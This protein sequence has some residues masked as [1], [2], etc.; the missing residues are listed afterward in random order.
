MLAH[1]SSMDHAKED[2]SQRSMGKE[3]TFSATSSK[4]EIFNILETLAEGVSQ[5]LQK[6]DLKGRTVTLKVKTSKFELF[7]R[8]RTVRAPIHS[9]EDLIKVGQEIYHKNYEK[10]ESS[11]RL[12]GISLSKFCDE[13]SAE[14]TILNF[15]QYKKEK[16]DAPMLAW[17]K[18]REER[19]NAEKV[20][21]QQS[22]K[23]LQVR[24]E[25][26]PTNGSEPPPKSPIKSLSKKSKSLPNDPS[27]LYRGCSDAPVQ[28]DLP[29]SPESSETELP[30]IIE[31]G[32][33]TSGIYD[34]EDDSFTEDL[35]DVEDSAEAILEC[36]TEDSDADEYESSSSSDNELLEQYDHASDSSC[37]ITDEMENDGSV[38]QC[39]LCHQ[40]FE[41]LKHID[42]HIYT[43]SCP[44]IQQVEQAA[45]EKRAK[46]LAKSSLERRN[47]QK[48]LK[49][50]S[51]T[52]DGSQSNSQKS[53]AVKA[54]SLPNQG[55]EMALRL[56]DIID[57]SELHLYSD[58][59]GHPE[60]DIIVKKDVRPKKRKSDQSK[61]RSKKRKS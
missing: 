14:K 43:A 53:L 46:D 8:S 47:S 60:A 23:S 33:T 15:F 13:K 18:Q 44:V 35:Q 17:D 11:I 57:P 20:A 42:D 29:E 24:S 32:P 5:E 36:D 41:R 6:A 34:I 1:G 12:L 52:S 55:E 38:I 3:T 4:T 59:H 19:K 39:P 7:T 21:K 51:V 50:R 45:E 56:E 28:S 2:R 48:S 54:L 30:V 16:F 27:Y 31:D 40:E 58:C 9:K 61:T 10:L 26:L 37:D 49:S 25:S 22:A